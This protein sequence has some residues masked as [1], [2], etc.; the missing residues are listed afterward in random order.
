MIKYISGKIF[1]LLDDDDDDDDDDGDED[2]IFS[3]KLGYCRLDFIFNV[4]KMSRCIIALHLNAV[5]EILS[6]R[7]DHPPIYIHREM[8]PPS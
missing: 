6:L 2:A 1:Y 3:R 8:N 5:R 7:C 4:F